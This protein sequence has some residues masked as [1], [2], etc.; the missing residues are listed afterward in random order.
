MRQVFTATF[1]HRIVDGLVVETWRN[2]DDLGRLIQLG[3]R[4][5][6]RWR[7]TPAGSPYPARDDRAG[8]PR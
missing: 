3:A 6:R 1:I 4:T 5:G 8:S 7:R 2:A